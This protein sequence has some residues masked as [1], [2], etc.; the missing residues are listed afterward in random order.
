MECRGRLGEGRRL[1]GIPFSTFP[2]WRAFGPGASTL[3]GW[4]S[5][6]DVLPR[7]SL[8]IENGRGEHWDSHLT[9]LRMGARCLGWNV[10]WL[11]GMEPAINAWVSTAAL[12]AC[13]LQL[14]P[15]S[16]S[17]RL[18]A[19]AD[20]NPPFRLQAM[21]HPLGDLR[22]DARAILKGLL[23]PWDILA[24]NR[25]HQRL[26]EDALLLWP[27]GTIAETTIAAIG[28]ELDGKLLMPPP[29]GRVSSI[30]EAFDLPFWARSRGLVVEPR[31][32]RLNEVPGGQLWCMNAV[33]GL[34]QAEVVQL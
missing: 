2:A 13:R 23:G 11:S 25:A 15:E 14:F 31:P 7:T 30:A 17:V 8:R 34:W 1:S 16:I 19:M 33:R 10:S 24:R 22:G 28:L 18:E 21:P 29:E 32:I 4:E 3:L 6:L 20:H 5:P 9:R 12:A 26:A 27:D